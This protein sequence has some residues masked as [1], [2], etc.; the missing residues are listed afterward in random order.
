VELKEIGKGCPEG[1][2]C[3]LLGSLGILSAS[4]L[5]SKENY[6]R[7]TSTGAIHGTFHKT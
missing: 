1:S 4:S 7:E 3:Y 5:A 2:H 6:K